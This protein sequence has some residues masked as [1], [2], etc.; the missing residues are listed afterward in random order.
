[1]AYTV[2]TSMTYATILD[3]CTTNEETIPNITMCDNINEQYVEY[4]V[5]YVITCSNTRFIGGE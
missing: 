3:T 2:L 4:I 5:N 1:M